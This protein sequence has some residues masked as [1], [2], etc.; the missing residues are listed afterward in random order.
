MRLDLYNSKGFNRG[1]SVWIEALWLVL[2]YFFISSW[3]PGSAYRI[4]LL[5]LFGAKIGKGVCIKPRVRVKFPWRLEIG[6]YSWIGEDVWIDN[7]AKVRIGSHCCLSQGVYLCTGSHNWSQ[8]NFELIYKPIFIEDKVWLCAKSIVAPGV[9][10][11]E[12]AVL[13]LGSVATKNLE[14]WTIYR[15]MTASLLSQRT[16]VGNTSPTQNN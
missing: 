12:G 2:Q 10:I 15:G 13:G 8:E 6:D 5:R 1:R 4:F 14:A 3:I 9:K 11:A 16:I 7:L